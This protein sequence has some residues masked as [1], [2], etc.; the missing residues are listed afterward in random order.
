ML[1]FLEPPD[2]P[3][4]RHRGVPTSVVLTRFATTPPAG[5]N[6]IS[7]ALSRSRPAYNREELFCC[8]PTWSTASF[9]LSARLA[10][11]GL[12]YGILILRIRPA[13]TFAIFN[14]TQALY[15]AF[16]LLL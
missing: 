15:L 14:V 3:D 4:V 6:N 12:F 16:A 5:L 2:T 8:L 10:E 1:P 11:G 7:F 9:I 13:D